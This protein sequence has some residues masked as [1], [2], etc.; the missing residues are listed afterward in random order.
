LGKL[1]WLCRETC[2]GEQSS[3]LRRG[4]FV[5]TRFR[6]AT[7][8]K[9]STTLSQSIFLSILIFCGAGPL[10]FILGLFS[11]LK[12]LAIEGFITRGGGFIT[13]VGADYDPRYGQTCDGEA[14]Y[15]DVPY[16]FISLEQAIGE[17]FITG[18][19]LFFGMLPIALFF[20]V[21]FYRGQN[22]K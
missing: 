2:I 17:H 18:S 6:R 3:E 20:G 1:S 4:L 19:K 13:C 12:Q 22:K 5:A 7:M 15:V 11:D 10:I 8:K 14:E 9:K 21:G 16:D